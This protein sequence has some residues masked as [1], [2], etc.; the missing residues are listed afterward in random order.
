MKVIKNYLWNVVYQIF[1]ILVPIVTIPYLTRVL[2]PKGI[3]INSFTYSISQYFVLIASIGVALYGSR[4]IAYVRNDSV[5]RSNTFWSIF[6]LKLITTFVA[7][8]SYS[9]FIIIYSKCSINLF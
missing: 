8:I 9:I 1:I 4:Q 2:G 7:I 5:E 3:G 6:I